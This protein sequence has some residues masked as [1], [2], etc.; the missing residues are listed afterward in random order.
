MTLILNFVYKI[1]L[2]Y[3]TILNFFFFFFQINYIIILLRN[4]IQID[5]I[6]IDKKILYLWIHKIKNSIVLFVYFK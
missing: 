1:I 3:L 2:I 5:K 6:Q 4:V